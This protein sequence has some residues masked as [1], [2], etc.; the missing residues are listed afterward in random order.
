VHGLRSGTLVNGNYLEPQALG[1]LGISGP[2]F[3]GEAKRSGLRAPIFP[4]A[5]DAA[6]PN[7]T[8]AERSLHG[9][10]LSGALAAGHTARW[11]DISAKTPAKAIICRHRARIRRRAECKEGGTGR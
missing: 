6:P 2:R 1:R 11:T 9:A 5:K 7:A 10:S 3:G 4:T 8:R